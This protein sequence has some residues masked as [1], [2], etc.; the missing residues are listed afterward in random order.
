MFYQSVIDE[1][2]AM[3]K[4]II[5]NKLTGIYLHGSMAMDCFNPEKSDIDLLIVIENDITDVQKME[6]RYRKRII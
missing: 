1:F 2:T 4:E 3:S 5:G 6:L